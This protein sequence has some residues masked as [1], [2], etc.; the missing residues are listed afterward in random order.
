MKQSLHE[1]QHYQKIFT[2][3]NGHGPTAPQQLLAQHLNWPVEVIVHTQSVC[4][5]INFRPPTHY[6]VDIANQDLMIAIEVDGRSHTWPE[7]IKQDQRK[8]HVLSLLG[9]KVLRFSNTEVLENIEQVMAQV[10]S[11]MTSK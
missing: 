1:R 10:N 6:K 7:R 2:G 4:H 5:L 11:Y 8:E 9:W 3:G